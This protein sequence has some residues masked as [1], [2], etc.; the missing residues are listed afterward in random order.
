[1]QIVP[2]I[3]DDKVLRLAKKLGCEDDPLFINVIT[4]PYAISR[5]CFASVEEKIRRSQGSLQLGWQIWEMPGVFI[6]AEFHAVWRSPDGI[7]IDIKPKTEKVKKILFI[8]DTKA[9]YDGACVNNVRINISNSR[10]VDDFI[11]TCVAI[12]NI[13]NGGNRAY[14][15][16]L[17]LSGDEALIYQELVKFGATLLLLIKANGSRNSPCF[18]GSGKKLK[19]C[20]CYELDR[21]IYQSKIE[22]R[23]SETKK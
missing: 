21:L 15:R 9:K 8:P 7:L 17:V 23:K 16:E 4:E 18:C 1:M 10:L 5:E 11:R 20:H 12:D 22:S 2:E 6:E 19:H 3:I 14:Q 13:K